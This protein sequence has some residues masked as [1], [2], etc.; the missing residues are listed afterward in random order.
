M[1]CIKC[2]PPGISS[3]PPFLGFST[4]LKGQITQEPEPPS[5][6]FAFIV[7]LDEVSGENECAE[8]FHSAVVSL[9][10]VSLHS[11]NQALSLI[12]I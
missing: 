6:L 4:P 9:I 2:F 7:V 11:S 8:L 10:A 1:L 5:F 3:T 12:H